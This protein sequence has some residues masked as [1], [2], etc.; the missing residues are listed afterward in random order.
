M[1]IYKNTQIQMQKILFLNPSLTAIYS[2][3]FRENTHKHKIA[4]NSL[5][6]IEISLH[7]TRSVNVLEYTC[8]LYGQNDLWLIGV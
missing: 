3:K 8:Y 7:R 1:K 6:K 4:V 5:R 2:F